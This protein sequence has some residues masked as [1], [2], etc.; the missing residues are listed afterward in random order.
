MPVDAK[1]QE[2]YSFPASIS[3]KKNSLETLLP[4]YPELKE[5]KEYHFLRLN[6]VVRYLKPNNKDFFAHL[7]CNDLVFI[8]YVKDSELI[9]EKISKIDA[10][11]QLIPDSWLSP[12]TKNAQIF[13]DWFE[14][15]N[16]YQL[17]YS[18]NQKMIE[19]VSKLFDNEL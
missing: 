12:E 3:I 6:K 1:T 16:C 9:C 15:L 11:Q 4:I 10:F 18:N 2:V 14:N 8:K 19:T 5:G 17:T 7:P 13:L